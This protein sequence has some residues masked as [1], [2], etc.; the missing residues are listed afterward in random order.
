[1]TYKCLQAHQTQV[2]QIPSSSGILNVLWAVYVTAPPVG[3]WVT[4]WP[5][6]VNDQ[7]TYLGRLYKCLQAHTSIATWNPLAT[8]NVLWQD[9]GAA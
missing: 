4:D 8:L 3:A 6:K 9:I 2:D 1:V 7:V 5:Y